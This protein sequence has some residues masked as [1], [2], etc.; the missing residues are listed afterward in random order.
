DIIA[1][2]PTAG[3][4]HA[5]LESVMGMFVNTLALRN[6][7]R[8][9]KTFRE[10]LANVGER[11]LQAFEN[12]E[13]PFEELVEKLSLDRDTGRNPLFDSMFVFQNINEPLIDDQP[14]KPTSEEPPAQENGGESKRNS[15]AKFDITLIVVERNNKIGLF[16]EYCSRLFKKETTRRFIAYFN[17]IVSS[18]VA[19]ANMKL[20]RIEIL[21]GEE[22]KRLL[23]DFN[24]TR[25]EYPENKTI[26]QLF[27]E[28]EE[29]TPDC[30]ALHM[31]DG[32]DTAHITYARLNRKAN[33]LAQL[34]QDKG[35][36]PGR[37]VAV[38]M[39]RSVEM[40]TGMLAILKTG[41]AYLPIDSQYPDERVKFILKDSRSLLLFT[42]KS[43]REK[44]EG[45]GCEILDAAE[46]G[47]YEDKNKKPLIA[48]GQPGDLAY[49]IYTSGSTGKPKGVM[50]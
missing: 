8:G 4:R 3:R 43:L 42:Q 44:G 7:P 41:G 48:A 36:V 9:G 13:Y 20:S 15:T 32:T 18:V 6:T 39:E 50:I 23:Y 22:K 45:T 47:L 17:K 30:I 37:I 24:N 11:T 1:G 25:I 28:Q 40:I 33:R 2:T 5:D 31:T 16:M 34:L 38:M 35:V 10:F 14:E 49:V 12:Q 27:E 21:P 26:H 19:D 29:K 46:T